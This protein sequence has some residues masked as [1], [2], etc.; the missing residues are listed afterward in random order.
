MRI[1]EKFSEAATLC[2]L[3]TLICVL[4]C[5]TPIH[6]GNIFWHLRNGVDIVETGDIRTEDPFT[7]TRHGTYWIQHEWLAESAMALSWIHIGEAGPVLLK[8]LFIGLSIF[9]VFKASLKNGAD[10][11]LIFVF[12]AFWLALA[13]PRWIA[14][15][16]FFSIFFF[17]LYLYILSFK[18]EKPWKLA[19]ILFPVQVLWVNVHAGFVMGLFLASVP[20]MGKLLTGK[21]SEFGKWL[22]P[23]AVLLLASG[24]HPNGFRTLEYLPAFLAQPLFKQSIREW[25]SPFDPRYAPEKPI[26]RTALLLSALTFGT[27]ALLIRFSKGIDRGKILALLMLIV[28][29]VFAA[30]NG[31]LL[32]PAMLAWVPGMLKLKIPMKLCAVSALILITIPFVYGVPREIGPPRELG[33]RVDW[34]VYPVDLANLLEEHPALM[35]HAV[36][37]NTNEISGYLEYRFGERFPLFVD[38]RC[39]LFPEAFHWDYLMLTEAPGEGFTA[40]QK[41]LFDRYEFNLL[42]Y[43]TRNQYSSVHMAAAL[44]CWVPIRIDALTSTYAK[45]E[46]LDETGL[47]SLAFRYFDPLDPSAFLTTPLYLL[48]S[49]AMNELTRQRNQLGSAILDPAIEA[50]LFRIDTTYTTETL[51]HE[52]VWSHTLACWEYC[53]KGDLSSAAV[54]ADLSGDPSIRAAVDFLQNGILAENQV[55]MSITPNMIR[56]R[57]DEKAACITSLWITGQQIKALHEAESS[58]DSL[59]PWGIAQCAWLYSLS[60]EQEHAEEL[61]N[62][63]LSR[64]RVPIVLERAARVFT[65]GRSYSRAIEYC[66]GALAMSPA[67]TGARLV[68]ADCLWELNRIEDAGTEYSWFGDNGFALPEYALERL[69]LLRKL[70]NRR[71]PA[72]GEGL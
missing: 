25:W 38:G 69:L 5:I 41:N 11:G 4:Y 13:Q 46:L 22:L 43:N 52:G 36:L 7:W 44:P 56:S 53:R 2:W 1:S 54:S 6:N 21:F 18:F 72:G 62:L 19:L 24:I 59:P 39:L 31:E 20:A 28:A 66:N 29:T 61:I 57:W 16:H 37:F 68:L 34:T 8:A 50:L 60:G 10:P 40:L 35:E 45:W 9:F 23:P 15:P 27:T 26:S 71:T 48:P 63:A 70:E 51:Q 47:D 12:G 65:T 58:M 30:R 3:L 49:T 17:S 33:A 55:I 64:A 14:R 32:A 67:Y 42:I